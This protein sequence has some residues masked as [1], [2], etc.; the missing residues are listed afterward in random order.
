MLA[1][2]DLV[3][4]CALLFP[5][6]QR[7]SSRLSLFRL[8]I[9]YISS[10]SGAVPVQKPNHTKETMDGLDKIAALYGGINTHSALYTGKMELSS[11]LNR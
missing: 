1:L 6:G 8:D 2:Q 3:L 7:Y 5:V 10:P 11:A 4:H 9:P